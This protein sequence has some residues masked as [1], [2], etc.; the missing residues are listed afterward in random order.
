M[1]CV[2]FPKLFL[3]K[4]EEERLN[5]KSLGLT[6]KWVLKEMLEKR[7]GWSLEGLGQLL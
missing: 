6:K 1:G 2:S 7:D 3:S 5:L 4:E